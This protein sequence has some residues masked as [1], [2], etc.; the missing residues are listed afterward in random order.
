[1]SRSIRIPVVACLFS[2]LALAAALALGRPDSANAHPLGN[3][4]INHYTRI[5]ASET[6][7]ELYRV[8]DMAEIPTVQER[9]RIDA[10]DDGEVDASESASYAE[11]KSAE[12]AAGL[13]LR[14]NGD[15]VPLIESRHELTFPD[16]EGGLLLL[17]LTV[18]Y[19]ADLRDDWRDA[20]PR[21]EFGDANYADRLGWREVIVRGGSGVELFENSAPAVDISAELTAY[22]EDSLS[23]PLDVRAATFG[24]RSGVGAPLAPTHPKQN[25]AVRGN[26]DGTLSRF[27][28][29]IA[30]D[31]LSA[32]VIAVALLGAV[33]FGALHALS[34]GHGKTVVA[35]YLIGW[36]GT[37][38]HAL[39][40]GLVVTAT[41]TSTVYLVG[42]VAL[43]LSQF[44]VPEDLY[45]WL[46]ITSGGLILAMGLGLFT[47]RL[48]AS[49]LLRQASTLLGARTLPR[50]RPRYA[51]AG[52][53]GAMAMTMPGV[54]GQQA[55]GYA[56][57]RGENH[58][59]DIVQEQHQ[60][61]H[62]DE[63]H[64]HGFGPAHSHRIPGQDGEPVTLRSL[65][66]LGVFGGMIPC[67]SAIVVMLS[68]IALHRVAFG[69]VLIVAFSLGLAAV[70]VA[71]GFA[72]VYARTI[73]DRAPLLQS[74]SGRI[75]NGGVT[76]TLARAFPVGAAAAVVV[77]GLIISLRAL[78]QQGL[79]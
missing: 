68:A 56:H 42:F 1:M 11:S 40:L 21:V 29:L 34:P 17:R 35:A 4:T 9:Q 27:S 50:Q 49:G 67:P 18:T 46:G 33:A 45:P 8:L 31:E 44:I 7:I 76:S 6:G 65:I 22:P 73:G 70:L 28:G 69:L 77:A 15:E 63:P 74:L 32:G 38:K 48:R 58:D 39:M 71:I 14:V 23:S 13:T 10:N 60:H 51:M 20:S 59:H 12:L 3:F 53:A 26:P 25:D 66:G 43:Y 16:G 36:R 78:A 5:D 30:R 61:E 52:E 24:V 2:M 41:H 79:I 47:S 54:R 72:L 19:A 75:Q 55:H 64:S 37:A 57:A 62:N